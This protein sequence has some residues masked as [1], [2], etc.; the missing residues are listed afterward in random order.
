MYPVGIRTW[1]W[2]ARSSMGRPSRPWLGL[3]GHLNSISGG[4]L[5]EDVIGGGDPD[6]VSEL[7][8]L[9]DMVGV[10]NGD[11]AKT[12]QANTNRH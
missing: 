8:I 3:E 6:S 9:L 10:R 1:K 2:L 12:N 4:E 7:V 5:L 11:S